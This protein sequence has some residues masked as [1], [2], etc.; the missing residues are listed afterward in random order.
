MRQ[1]S[2]R[3]QLSLIGVGYVLVLGGA[4]VIV[5]RRLAWEAANPEIVMASSGMYAGGDMLLAIFVGLLL[6][7][8]TIFLV[9]LLSQQENTALLLAKA[10]LALGISAPVSL[11]SFV[12]GLKIAP[13]NLLA[14]GFFRL[15]GSPV[16]LPLLIASWFLSKFPRA[17]RLIALATLA[18]GFALAGAI[19]LL[20]FSHR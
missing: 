8:P 15:L 5:Y 20:F 6:L 18:E 17:R 4:S 12:I 3:W 2:T 16:V 11:T 19:A 10:L 7:V 9:R 14:L 1:I 13:G